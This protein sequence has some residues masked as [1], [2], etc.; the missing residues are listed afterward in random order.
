MARSFTNYTTDGCIVFEST[1]EKKPIENVS[2]SSINYTTSSEAENEQQNISKPYKYLYIVTNLCKIESLE[3]RLLPEYRSENP[4]NRFDALYIFYQ[5]V[6][7]VRYLHNAMNMV[8][9]L[10]L[11]FPYFSIFF[12]YL[13]SL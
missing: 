9:S 10:F 8:F 11:F 3:D 4:I 12:L 2:S 7:G 1:S 13:D 6:S 5:I